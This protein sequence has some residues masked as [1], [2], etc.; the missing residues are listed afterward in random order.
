MI[1]KGARQA[2]KTFTIK[3]VLK[4]NNLN[5]Y[6]F[7]LIENPSLKSLFETTY[8]SSENFISYLSLIG[9]K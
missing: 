5:F 2:G 7:N 1:I 8:D 6:E 4:A 3:K 9:G